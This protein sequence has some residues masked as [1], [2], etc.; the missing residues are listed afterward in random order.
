MDALQI[1]DAVQISDGT[2]SMVYGFG[3]R[4]SSLKTPT[5]Y[6]QVFA[7]NMDAGDPL[8]IS[9]EHLIYVQ[10]GTTT[11]QT[12]PKLVAAGD[13]KV[14]D[15]LWTVHGSPSPILWIRHVFRQGVYAPLTVSG[16][17]LVNGV[18]ASSYV[19][20]DW[21]KDHVSGDTLHQFQHG[22]LLPV[23]LVCSS[24]VMNC[25]HWERYNN[26]TGY[27]TWVQFWFD[28][29]Q[30]MLRLPLVW[31]ASFL[32]LLLVPAALI[33]L[34]GKVLLMPLHAWVVQGV[35]AV[36]GYLIWKGGR[37]RKANQPEANVGDKRV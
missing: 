2:F 1:G 22:A 27:A 36:V 25:G 3:H 15:R 30:W 14:G 12:A 29:E 23:R 16:N 21:L 37:K 33:T 18:L 17:L 28:I 4:A 6:L 34:A 7:S 5:K 9:P 32:T 19:S 13:L 35:I 8:E 10:S 11:L 31:R 20:R 24:G 26:V